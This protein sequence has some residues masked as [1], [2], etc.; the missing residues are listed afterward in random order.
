MGLC[1]ATCCWMAM[2]LK[3][4]HRKW[5]QPSLSS[6]RVTAGQGWRSTLAW[7]SAYDFW[8]FSTYGEAFR[9][10]SNPLKPLSNPSPSLS[11]WR[12]S[13]KCQ[14][15]LLLIPPTVVPDKAEPNKKNNHQNK[16]GTSVKT[17]WLQTGQKN[18][19]EKQ[20]EKTKGNSQGGR[21]YRSNDNST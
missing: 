15:K 16:Q 21:R 12:H 13:G 7:H 17:L 18:T 1:S 19:V 10:T 5:I 20:G 8:V 3:G 9:I 14:T 2:S 4:L 11:D 6:Y